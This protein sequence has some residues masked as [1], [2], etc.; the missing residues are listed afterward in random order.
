MLVT[1][2]I[3]FRTAFLD[4][5]TSPYFSVFLRFYSSLPSLHPISVSCLGFWLAV[6][7]TCIFKMFWAQPSL[8]WKVGHR[9]W[10]QVPQERTDPYHRLS[11]MGSCCLLVSA[12]LRP[13]CVRATQKA[14]WATG[15]HSWLRKLGHVYGFAF[16]TSFQVGL[17]CWAGP[18]LE[19]HSKR[20]SVIYRIFL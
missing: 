18:H 1:D 13:G 19:G 3:L 11:Q 4:P 16:L 8:M 5:K 7:F 9:A 12:S 17:G 20:F 6:S 2:L 15:D 10:N 14:R